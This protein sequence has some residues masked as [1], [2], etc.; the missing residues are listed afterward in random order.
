M[1]GMKP[2][3]MLLASGTLLWP[4]LQWQNRPKRGPVQVRTFPVHVSVNWLSGI[5]ASLYLWTESKSQRIENISVFS[6]PLLQC[7]LQ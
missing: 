2:V 3:L 1:R 7:Y 5:K 6:S 4:S